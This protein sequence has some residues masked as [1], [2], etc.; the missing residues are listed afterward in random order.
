MGTGTPVLTPGDGDR[1]P[2]DA[3]GSPGPAVQT[4]SAGDVFATLGTSPRG[5]PFAEVAARRD[6]FGPNELPRAGRGGGGETSSGSSPT[7]SR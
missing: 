1:A 7:S 2:T 5:L 4:V 6:R 3:S